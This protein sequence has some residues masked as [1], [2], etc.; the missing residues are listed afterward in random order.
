M[1]TKTYSLVT[2]TEVLLIERK[3]QRLLITFAQKMD[4]GHFDEVAEL[5][6]HAECDVKGI[7]S[8]GRDSVENFFNMTVRRHADGTPRTLH[9]I[10]NVAVT[11]DPLGDS[12]SSLSYYIVHQRIEGSPLEPV[13]AGRW[14]D[15]F[16]LCN[17]DWRFRSHVDEPW[18][19]DRAPSLNVAA[20]YD[21]SR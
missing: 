4:D 16:E 15:T 2:E 18:L 21:L 17:G 12:A 9:F 19:T 13:S 11:I 5:F 1:S 10:T 3:I 14:H 8:V 7:K 20:A 6:R